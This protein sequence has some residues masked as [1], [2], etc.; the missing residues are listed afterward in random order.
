MQSRPGVGSPCLSHLLS[1]LLQYAQYR[2]AFEDRPVATAGKN[3]AVRLFMGARNY[4]HTCPCC[5]GS[6][7][8]KLTSGWNSRCQLCLRKPSML[9]DQGTWR[10]A[11]TPLENYWYMYPRNCRR[12]SLAQTLLIRVEEGG[13]VP[14]LEDRC[15]LCPFSFS[16]VCLLKAFFFR[17]SRPSSI[18]VEVDY[19]L[20][21]GF[22]VVSLHSILTVFCSGFCF[23]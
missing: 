18:M 10:T 6:I 21:A 3:A 22:L 2:V 1:Q 11:L 5:S 4:D 19:V 9:S 12:H 13:V 14:S 23:F 15:L 17:S 7:G 16:F 8:Y 20:S